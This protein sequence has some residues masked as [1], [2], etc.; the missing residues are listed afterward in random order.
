MRATLNLGRIAG[1]KV[2]IHWT[3]WLLILFVVYIVFARGGSVDEMFW[4]AFFILALFVCVVLHEFGHA[5]TARRYGI[6]TRSITLLPI[7]GVA[8]LNEMPDDPMAEFM[9]AIAGP[10][11]NV[12]IAILLY[13]IV[14]ID[15]FMNQD[16]ETLQEELSAV[17]GSNFLFYLF[18]ANVA[19]VLFN[20]LP[21]FPLDG[22]RVLRAA[23]SVKMGRV[24]ATR[25][26]ATL[27]KFLA[28]TFF[29]FGLFYNLILTLIAV[30]IYFGAESENVMVMQLNLLKNYSIKDAMITRFTVL[31]PDHTLDNVVDNILEGTEQD[32]IV[33]ENNKVL[34]ILRMTDLA[35]ALR[36]E[37]RQAPVKKVMDT[38]FKTLAP[39]DPLTNAYREL[40]S[41]QKN[42]FPVLENQQI[43]G[44]V[45][46]DNINEFLRFRA[47]AG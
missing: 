29:F 6:G 36:Q 23:L 43:V 39:N 1:I 22:G 24:E 35:E 18:F 37:S 31:H 38:S 45:D 21:A 20:M 15:M 9:V 26:A 7:G 42:F 4:N 25:T 5:L 3:F 19:L 47:S 27:G 12:G 44:V 17:T 41:S 28:F 16:P 32:F 10:L 2:Q 46:M 40:I 8:S 14:P 33:A 11:V 34:G 13:L 30:F